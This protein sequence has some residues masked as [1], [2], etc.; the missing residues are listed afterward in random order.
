M[1]LST[2]SQ[3]LERLAGAIC[4]LAV[5]A[6]AVYA[7]HK[8]GQLSDKAQQTLSIVNRP[9]GKGH[10]CG[11]LAELN[12]SAVKL[13]DITVTLQRQVSQSAQLVDAASTSIRRATTDVHT[14][15]T[16]GAG[17]L[18]QATV[19]LRAGQMTIDAA[20]PLLSAA[21]GSV[22]KFGTA[23]DDLDAQIKAARVAEMSAAVTA[24][25]NELT[26]TFTNVSGITADGKKVADKATADYLK[27]V[28]WYMQP[29]HRI[30]EFWDITAAVARH[31][32]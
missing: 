28:K 25:A 32:P 30:G 12:K 2:A 16:A 18:Q 1:T 17:M 4:L 13:Q 27:P 3:M 8:I 26:K 24:S 21:T 6:S 9:C 14:M 7:A 23:A 15:A 22:T 5:A 11:T 31:T 19:T 20:Q 29:V 10:P